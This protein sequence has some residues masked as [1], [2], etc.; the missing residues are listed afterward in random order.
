VTFD[1]EIVPRGR[2]EAV[3]ETLVYEG[4]EPAGWTERDVSA[5]LKAVL[6]A[7]DRAAHP[8]Q[9][10]RPVSLR[11]FSWIVEPFEGRVVIAVEI[12]DG[13]AVAGPFAIEQA[14]LDALISR[15]IAAERASPSG[16][17]RVH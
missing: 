2:R 5:V 15:A 16:P 1:V 12:G 8:E 6:G 4:P 7:I 14:R 17:L 9:E 13:A 10:P 3:T 11:G